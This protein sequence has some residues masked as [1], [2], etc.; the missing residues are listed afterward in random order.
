MI[1][2]LIKGG[3]AVDER[4][5]LSFVNDFDFDGVKRFYV[6]RNHAPKFLRAWHGHKNETKY[7]TVIT[8]VA[9]IA[10]VE[11]DNWVAPDKDAP[12][13]RFIMSEHNP[14]VL[15]IP[16]GYANGILTLTHETVVQVFST[17]T[18]EESVDDDYRYPARYWNPWGVE[19][20]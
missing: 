8:G 10:A 12:V 17:S 13:I 19:E 1:P 15:R 16:A 14:Q 2:Q 18:L 5:R 3:T 4:G 20:R 7:V 9:I 11:I 6:M